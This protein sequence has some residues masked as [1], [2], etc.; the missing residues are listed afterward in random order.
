MPRGN[1]GGGAAARA[2][3]GRG[4]GK[5]KRGGGRGGGPGG[6]GGGRGGRGGGRGGR[7]GGRG[8]KGKKK[9]K[10]PDWKCKGCGETVFGS[11]SSCFKCGASKSGKSSGGSKVAT[12]VQLDQGG[13]DAIRDALAQLMADEAA[14]SLPPLA[15]G[16]ELDAK[17]A[18]ELKTHGFAKRDIDSVAQVLLTDSATEV[19]TLALALNWLLIH[20]PEARLP[21]SMRDK[22]HAVAKQTKAKKKS[23]GKGGAK[24]ERTPEQKA[25]LTLSALGFELEN[26][27]EAILSVRRQTVIIDSLKELF[28]WA[29]IFYHNPLHF[30]PHGLG[31]VKNSEVKKLAAAEKTTLRAFFG[32]NFKQVRPFFMSFVCSILL[33]SH[34]L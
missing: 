13:R 29:K 32:A 8:G 27:I 1:R 24:R 19:P 34:L 6:R 14:T 22:S 18:G 7:G 11:K 33:F 4:G 9:G 25:A 12:S 20:I 21:R 15:A 10:Q 28:G 23:G 26:C 2:A 16:V 17:L 30:A 3:K 31:E 5:A